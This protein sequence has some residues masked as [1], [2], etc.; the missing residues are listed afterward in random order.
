MSAPVSFERILYAVEGAIARITLNRP[1]K[2]NALDPRTLEELP[3]AFA[4]AEEDA[5][6]KVIALGA[7]G[8]DFCAGLD[9]TTLQPTADPAVFEKM[10]DAERLVRLFL[11]M[12][13]L[14]KPIVALVRGRALGGGCGLATA[15][16]VVLAAESAQFGYPEVRIGF[17]PAIVS[18]LL[19]RSVGEKKAAEL[20]LS[21]RRI[22]AV[23]AERL[24]L[25]TS[26]FPDDAFEQKSEE[27]LAE[28]AKQSAQAMRLTKQILYQ[29]DGMGF[30][31]AMQ[32]A[33][34]VNVLARLTEDFARGITE[35]LRK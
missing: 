26:V 3:R 20:M 25:V 29:I 21:G 23:E 27:F 1:E 19:R 32:A 15:C 31:A 6:V 2:R 30:E 28:L 24:G 10:Q 11:L 16:D 5:A 13:R 18:V 12:R 34:E 17:V 22:T 35:F 8:T 14:P 7:A 9:V 33:V 4:C